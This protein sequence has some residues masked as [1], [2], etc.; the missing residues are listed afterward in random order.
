MHLC[1]ARFD[2]CSRGNGCFA[3][4]F[5]VMLF[6]FV[7]VF[8]VSPAGDDIWG[9]RAA[10]NVL[11]STLKLKEFSVG[12]RQSW[13]TIVTD[14]CSRAHVSQG[15]HAWP[16]R[17]AAVLSRSWWEYNPPWLRHVS[18]A[19]NSSALLP[20]ALNQ[21]LRREILISLH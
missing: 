18:L 8:V 21:M 3:P 6:V 19:Y 13:A 20:I 15:C 16:L 2:C 7:C 14:R 10:N 17:A 9:F 5:L 1:Q 12:F 11:V 4:V